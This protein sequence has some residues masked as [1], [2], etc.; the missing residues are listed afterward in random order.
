MIQHVSIERS[1]LSAQN[2]KCIFPKNTS[3]W[4]RNTSLKLQWSYLNPKKLK[5]Y[6]LQILSWFHN[7]LKVY[8]Y[9][10][11]LICPYKLM[12]QRIFELSNSFPCDIENIFHYFISCLIKSSFNYQYVSWLAIID[13]QLISICV[14]QYICETQPLS[15]WRFRTRSNLQISKNCEYS[16]FLR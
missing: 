9:N 1:D 12:K 13:S 4:F 10:G 14:G 3:K 15:A 5:I 16:R 7:L 2:M 8:L 6:R 11:Y